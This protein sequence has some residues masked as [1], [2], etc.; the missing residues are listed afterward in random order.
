MKSIKQ[1]LID[2]HV[3]LDL[4]EVFICETTRTATFWLGN[5]SDMYVGYQVYRPDADKTTK[6]DEKGRY[7]THRGEKLIPRKSK[8]VALWGLESYNLSNVLFVTEGIFDAARFTKMGFSAV[9]ALAN[10]PDKSTRNW[11]NIVSKTRKVVAICDSGRPGLKLRTVGQSYYIMK[12]LDASEAP[13][14]EIQHI[15]ETYK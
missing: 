7:Y 5:L 10:D 11:F 15:L 2:R 12:D 4:H 1:N 14:E 3:D 13:E 6:N 8:T 9:A